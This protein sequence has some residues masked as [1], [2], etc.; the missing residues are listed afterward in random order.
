MKLLVARPDD[1]LLLRDGWRGEERS[2]GL[3]RA[4][5]DVG[6]GQVEAEDFIAVV[7][8]VS[9]VAGY[10]GRTWNVSADSSAE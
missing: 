9:M 7:A 8:G 1:D 2:V 6:A 3:L 10:G 4:P 5:E